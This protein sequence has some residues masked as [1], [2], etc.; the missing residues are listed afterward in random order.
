MRGRFPRPSPG[1]IPAIGGVSY[2]EATL[3]VTGELIRIYG[4]EA[5]PVPLGITADPVVLE[6]RPAWMVETI[7]QVTIGER[8][9]K[10]RWTF[11]VGSSDGRPAVLRSEGPGRLGTAEVWDE[12][13]E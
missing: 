2:E 12:R 8:I 7:V 10:R 3:L 6:G 13:P 9:V 11:W 4:L 1:G 5:D